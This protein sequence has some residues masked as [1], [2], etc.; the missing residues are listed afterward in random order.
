MDP[1]TGATAITD[2]RWVIEEDKTFYVNPALHDEHQQRRR[3]PGCVSPTATSVPPTFGVNFHTSHMEYIA[4]GCT[5]TASTDLSCE[6]AR[7]SSIPRP[8]RM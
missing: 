2:Y 1:T 6:R 4:Q 3:V 5:G 8:E 7:Q